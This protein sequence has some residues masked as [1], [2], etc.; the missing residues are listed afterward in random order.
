MEQLQ[1]YTQFLSQATY[2]CYGVC[3]KVVEIGC[4]RTDSLSNSIYEKEATEHAE[5]LRE[6]LER[7][8]YLSKVYDASKYV[9]AQFQED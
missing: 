7:A 1:L 9:C 8:Q 3:R 5:N 2:S 6:G 4:V